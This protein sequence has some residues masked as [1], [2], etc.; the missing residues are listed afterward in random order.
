MKKENE[1]IQHNLINT[2][3]IFELYN[4][5]NFIYP[6]KKER[7]SPVF[8]EITENWEKAM[9]LNFPLFWVSTL[10]QNLNNILSTGTA[11]QY[12]NKGM[13]AQHLCSNHPIGSRMIFL[14]M[15]NKVIENQH[16]GFIESYQLY[17]QPQ[18]KYSSKIF[19]SLSINSGKEL[20]EIIPY[21]YHELPFLTTDSADDI[22]LIEINN[23]NISDDFTSFLLKQRGELF[24]KAQELNSDDINLT[25]LNNKFKR[26]GLKR[27][28][29]VFAA[30][31]F[32]SDKIYGVIIINESSLGFN[33]SFFENS[34]EL[35]L[36]NE[37]NPQFLLKIIKKLLFKASE[38]N[39][40]S[41]L[42][43]LPVLTDPQHSV[44]IEKLNGKVT[45][46]YNLFIMLKGGYEKWYEHVDR[47]TNS[48]FQRFINNYYEKS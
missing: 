6:A 20:S 27:T 7:I 23:S 39:L 5:L 42:H 26:H 1:F 33:F 8:S 28:R 14:G 35:I 2:E 21:N 15:L 4:L 24:I 22:G 16:K 29:R 10:K 9:K 38:I 25:N 32:N 18:N 34:C 44:L 45:R 17:Y 46:N 31:T 40:L 48:I 47:L 43:F 36:C 41:S 12:L 37:S 3:Q 11:W 30:K 19:E 13:I